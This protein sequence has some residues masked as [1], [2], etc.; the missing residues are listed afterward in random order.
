MQR[1]AYRTTAA[2]LRATWI[3]QAPLGTAKTG[4]TS[5]SE[6]NY[7]PFPARSDRGAAERHEVMI[8]GDEPSGSLKHVGKPCSSVNS[9]LMAQFYLFTN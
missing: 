9:Q 6:F 2:H 8:H 5:Q 4:W 7:I 1:E 3:V